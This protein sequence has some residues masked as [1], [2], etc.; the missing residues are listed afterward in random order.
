MMDTNYH[1]T[2]I[3]TLDI[4]SQLSPITRSTRSYISAIEAGSR[5]QRHELQ[6][7]QVT[8]EAELQQLYTFHPANWI[9]QGKDPTELSR[10]ARRIEDVEQQLAAFEAAE[11]LIPDTSETRK[12]AM[13]LLAQIRKHTSAGYQSKTS[14]LTSYVTEQKPPDH[15]SRLWIANLTALSNELSELA[16]LTGCQDEANI[17]LD[18]LNN[19]SIPLTMSELT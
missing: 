6:I 9:A 16:T 15:E 3:T 12:R 11:D 17:I 8:L 7:A 4:N 13:K 2:R 10:V 14:L 19:I 1:Y 5:D 18:D